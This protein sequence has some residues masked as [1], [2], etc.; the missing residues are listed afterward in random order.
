MKQH[1]PNILS[2]SRV[3][4]APVVIYLYLVDSLTAS[5]IAFIMLVILELTD[6]LDGY[7]ARKFNVVGDIGKALDPFADTLLHITLF[8][9]FLYDGIMPMW[10]YLIALYRDM[11]SMFIRI[12]TAIR[13]SVL[14]AKFSGKL[15]TFFRAISVVII[16]ILNILKNKNIDLPYDKIAYYSLLVVTIITIYSFFDYLPL[17]KRKR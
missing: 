7:Y 1:I 12:I 14:P 16:F 10:M 9:I 5:I 11:F 8:T 2:L 15:K 6:A 17:L 13:G 3:V 4:L